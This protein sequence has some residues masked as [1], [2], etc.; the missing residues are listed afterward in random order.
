MIIKKVLLVSFEMT[1]SGAP[2]ATLK[3]A[4]VL[5]IL[6]YQVDIWSLNDGPFTT[7][8]SN[9]G[10]FVNSIRF[11]EDSGNDLDNQLSK[12]DF[13]ICHTIFCAEIACYIQQRI[14]TVLY[15]HEAG[16]IKELIE[17]CNI[18]LDDFLSIKKYWCVSEYA[19]QKILENYKLN[20]LDILPNYVV[21]NAPAENQSVYNKKLR[22]CMA[23]TVE[24]RKGLDVVV[25]ALDL[26]PVEQQGFVELHVVG[27]IPEWTQ[28]YASKYI[29]HKCV[30]YHSEVRDESVLYRLYASM[31]L[32]IVAS[33]DE[34]CSLVALEAAML[35]KPLLVTE[36][37][38]ANYV[39]DNSKMILKTGDAYELTERIQEFLN[40]PSLIDYEG[41]RNYHQYKKKASLSIYK[42]KL[43]HNIF[44]IKFSL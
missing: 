1:Y 15:I 8:F 12:Y 18:K 23:G 19:K 36:N 5:R 21:E 9:D 34:S 29:N 40:N 37:T 38:G 14:K 11:P 30:Q 42:K 24:Y 20:S 6:G 41:K 7:E 35:K 17:A 4:R 27:R 2:I 33:R 44:K 3:M 25:K 43:K 39:V 13:C 22:L 31:D 16:N 10:F 28:S 26:L 32:F